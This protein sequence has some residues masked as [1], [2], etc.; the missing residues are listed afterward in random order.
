MSLALTNPIPV[1]LRGEFNGLANPHHS[2]GKS[3]KP[4]SKQM[5]HADHLQLTSVCQP[6]VS[7]RCQCVA[8]VSANVGS[9]GDT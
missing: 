2:L 6:A 5:A 9:T 3:Q 8:S 7:L 1:V 4:S